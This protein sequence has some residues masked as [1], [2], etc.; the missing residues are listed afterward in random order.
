MVAQDLLPQ[1][2]REEKADMVLICEQYRCLSEPNCVRDST[3]TPAIWVCEEL[4]ISKKID[5]P[6]PGFIWVEVA[7]IRLYIWYLPPSDQ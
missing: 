6:L 2:V 1:L 7:G 5:V 3:S 4:H